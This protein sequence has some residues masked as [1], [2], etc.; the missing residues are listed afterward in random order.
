M[1]TRP[2]GASVGDL[3]TALRGNTFD[4]LNC[5]P[6]GTS[7]NDTG[8]TD[9]DVFC[10]T[11]YD[12]STLAC[13]NTATCDNSTSFLN[14]TNSSCYDFCTLPVCPDGP[15]SNPC[16]AGEPTCYTPPPA[17]NAGAWTA[18]CRPT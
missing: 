14:G 7:V 16:D 13:D 11:S 17:R 12:N 15:Y 18:W 9:P 3:L 5:V 6:V 2:L 4:P 10:I 8:C 1:L